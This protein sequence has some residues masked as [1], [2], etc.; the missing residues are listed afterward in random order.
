MNNRFKI[1]NKR[2]C[3][4]QFCV[5]VLMAVLCTFNI[6]TILGQEITA[7]YDKTQHTIV[8]ENNT[9]KEIILFHTDDPALVKIKD[10]Q[11]G[12]AS[13]TIADNSKITNEVRRCGLE[14]DAVPG[15]A[16]H[17]SKNTKTKEITQVQRASDQ[18]ICYIIEGQSISRF[19]S[20][21]IKIK[22]GDLNP[23]PS[24]PENV[25][26]QL[27]NDTGSEIKLETKK[28]EPQKTEPQKEIKKIII[29]PFTD[30]IN[31]II[32]YCNNILYKGNLSDKDRENLNTL[33]NEISDK[34]DNL[35]EYLKSLWDKKRDPKVKCEDCDVLILSSEKMI[36][37]LDNMRSK[38]INALK[39]V[40]D[41]VVV[42]W[43]TE[44]RNTVL[45]AQSII[46]RDI[47]ALLKIKAQLEERSQQSLLGWIGKDKL[48]SQL[49]PIKQRYDKII[50][51]SKNFIDQ[52]Q[53]QYD[54]EN[55]KAAIE[56]LSNEIPIEYKE[57]QSYSER[58]AAIQIPYSMLLVTGVLL[59]LFLF[60]IIFYLTTILK[61]RTLAKKEKQN[62]DSGKGGLLIEDVD[63][64]IEIIS[65]KVGLTDVIAA[66]GKDYYEVNILT[67]LDDTGI[68]SVYFSRK[69]ILDIYKFFSGFLKYDDKTNE[70]G[71]F[72]VGRWDYVP[73]TGNKMY[74]ISIEA[75]VE[76]GDDAVYGEYNLNFGAKIGITLNYALENLCQRSGN[77]YVHTAWMHSHPGL[78]LF[79]SSQD[80]N[81]Q[82]QL[83]HSQHQ[84]RL[85]AIVIDSNS[86]DFQMAFFTPKQSG[87][88]NND[89]DLKQTLALETMYQ[90]AKSLPTPE[91]EKE[92]TSKHSYYSLDIKNKATQIDKFLVSGAAII[93][94]DAVIMP[95]VFGLQGCFYGTRQGNEIIVDELKE[96]TQK[97]NNAMGCFV[98]VPK[99]SLQ[100]TVKEYLQQ[101]SE[102]DFAIFYSSENREIYILI[103][104]SSGN[105]SETADNITSIPLMTMKEWTRRKRV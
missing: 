11:I 68:K 12:Y 48:E 77:E 92:P 36:A 17:I 15:N 62:R 86:P 71:C 47:E 83:A 16:T 91:K 82:S 94:I 75:L 50:E 27:V 53:K 78:G 88:M 67:L 49:T 105:Y 73:N 102:F 66:A 41:S 51:N 84:S 90:W 72:L 63:D 98:T 45:P 30:Q 44:Y 38:I 25:A 6:Q 13:L 65:Y 10:N 80:L 9:G 23:K 28:T 21:P 42:N 81:V 97:E 56:D 39:K 79:L 40:D 20:V 60:G 26:L 52:K 103:K 1:K 87:M 2:P 34:K 37:S 58:I 5:V 104:D 54:D 43:K 64:F 69:A 33:R 24:E 19:V 89:K 55:D 85:L 46:D 29:N 61:N 95:G 18:L 93:D 59:L 4:T 3:F 99:F 101:L 57:I 7:T 100:E 14:F 35:E 70:T 74:N 31:V 96:S 8:V 22:G 32:T 76:P